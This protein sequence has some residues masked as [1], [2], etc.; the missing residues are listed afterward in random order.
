MTYVCKTFYKKVVASTESCLINL[1]S[2]AKKMERRQTI[3]CIWGVPLVNFQ[4]VYGVDSWMLRRGFQMQ[5]SK[6]REKERFLCI[7][8]IF[9]QEL[10]A[11]AADKNSEVCCKTNFQC[12]K[13][14]GLS[15]EQASF[16]HLYDLL[17]TGNNMVFLSKWTAFEK[18]IPLALGNSLKWHPKCILARL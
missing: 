13:W 4:T 12:F 14:T 15:A 16:I 5:R 1:I 8:G 9:K 17:I 10:W 7:Y 18:E 2:Y 11:A 6:K 3:E